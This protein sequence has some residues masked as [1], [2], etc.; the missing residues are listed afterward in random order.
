MSKEDAIRLA[1]SQAELARI[2]GVTRGAVNQWKAVPQGR[3]W[4][5]RVLKP[6]WFAGT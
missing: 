3:I 1:G 2:L 5:L 4:Q 6:D